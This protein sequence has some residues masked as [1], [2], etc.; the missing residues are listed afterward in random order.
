MSKLAV[1]GPSFWRST[2]NTGRHRYLL[3]FV[4]GNDPCQSCQ[5]STTCG[6]GKVMRTASPSAP[7]RAGGWRP[8]RNEQTPAR[9]ERCDFECSTE[10]LEDCGST[11]KSTDAAAVNAPVVQF[12]TARASAVF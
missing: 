3:S 8:A 11:S 5:P 7:A 4:Q 1:Q 12:A 2:N 6:F 9:S 10:G